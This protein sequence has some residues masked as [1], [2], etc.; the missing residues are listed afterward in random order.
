MV[1]V[2]WELQVL[3]T[4]AFIVLLL[5][6]PIWAAENDP[7]AA[8][9]SASDVRL[10]LALKDKRAVFQEGEIIP[11]VLS[12]TS[13]AK[14]RYWA[15]TRNYDRSGRLDTDRYCVE[16][17]AP[18][19]LASYFKFGMFIGGGLGGAHALDATPFVVQAELNEWRSPGP[20]HYRVYVVSSRIYRPPDAN[21]QTAYGQI[22]ETVRS[23]T[24]EFEVQSAAGTW[25]SEQVKSAA[26]TLAGQSSPEDA[27]RAARIL[28]YL[29][30]RDSTR[31][32]A[33]L[34]W[35]LNEQQ[36]AGWDLMFGL[37]GSPYRQLALDSMRSEF[38]V[39]G[40][41]ITAEFLHTLV[42][43]QVNSD[44]SW[45]PPSFDPAHP[46]PAQEFWQHRQAHT[47]ELL[48]AEI[49]R[50]VSV[51][52]RKTGAA[53]ALT[54]N[55]LLN[56]G[57]DDP[58]LAQVIRPALIAAWKDLPGNTQ[59]ELIQ[60]R[61]SLIADP[62][63]LPIL[64]RMVA[65][66]PPQNRTNPAMAR[67]AALLHIHELDPVAGCALILRDLQNVNAQP[68]LKIVK[69]LSPADIV[70]AMQPALERISHNKARDLDYE[71][72]D[73]Y[74]DARAL[75]PVQAVFEEHL[76]ERDRST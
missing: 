27:R 45:D 24:V 34:F 76:G 37:Y 60:Y 49:Q 3:R 67:D 38:A 30:T 18:D 68:S 33:K 7:C 20:G 19:P 50:L 6:K 47:A 25:Q 4:V 32:L 59:M 52:S 36:P 48:K 39:P 5:A 10:L 29:R 16:P 11:L 43:L 2:E 71:L 65:E 53:R 73:H 66:P 56:A 63:M 17:E 28:R 62:E 69:L 58:A 13:T 22:Y 26:Q 46:E 35:G 74:A 12:F 14:N 31:Q 21:E 55:G 64:N 40:H 61:W 51:L 75:S 70:I 23:N 1:K 54:L 41:A 72:L 9:S 8:A 15:D 42:G 57:G 44:P